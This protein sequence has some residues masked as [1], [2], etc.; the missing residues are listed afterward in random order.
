M[1]QSGS[2]R[3]VRD[4]ASAFRR[5]TFCGNCDSRSGRSSGF[6]FRDDEEAI[7]FALDAPVDRNAALVIS[8]RSKPRRSQ[9]EARTGDRNE[10]PAGVRCGQHPFDPEPGW[11]FRAGRFGQLRTRRGSGRVGED[12]PRRP[13][14]ASRLHPPAEVAHDAKPLELGD[15]TGVGEDRRHPPRHSIRSKVVEAGSDT[16]PDQQRS[17]Q[18]PK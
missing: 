6:S 18:P 7:R 16:P 14:S 12:L 5:K 1:T 2:V 11:R 13:R 8:T 15:G 10:K 17:R 3:R 4:E 9:R